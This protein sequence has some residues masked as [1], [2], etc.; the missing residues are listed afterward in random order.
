MAVTDSSGTGKGLKV[1]DLS[2]DPCPP[3][4]TGEVLAGA[5]GQDEEQAAGL[6]GANEHGYSYALTRSSSKEKTA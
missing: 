2:L 3:P 6:S 4:A 1:V 5:V